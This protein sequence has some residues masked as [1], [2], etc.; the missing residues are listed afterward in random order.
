MLSPALFNIYLEPLLRE[1][2]RKLQILVHDILIFAYAD[3]LLILTSN[4]NKIQTIIETIESF[5]YENGLKLNKSKSGIV[6]FIARH[7]KAYLN[8]KDVCNVTFL[9]YMSTNALVFG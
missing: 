9:S 5:S 8:Y 3:D 6:E 1:L 7:N 4:R 2:D